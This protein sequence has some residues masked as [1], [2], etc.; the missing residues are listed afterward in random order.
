MFSGIIE[1]LGTV[2]SLEKDKDNL[3]IAV[4]NESNLV[5]SLQILTFTAGGVWINEFAG[6]GLISIYH[7]FLQPYNH[8][9]YQPQ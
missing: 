7:N 6:S 8:M 9:I 5:V 3:H 4:K 2:V 1:T